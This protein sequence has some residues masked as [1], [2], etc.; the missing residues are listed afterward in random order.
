MEMEMME[1]YGGETRKE[2]RGPNKSSGR[3]LW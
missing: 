3:M 2:Y 1:F